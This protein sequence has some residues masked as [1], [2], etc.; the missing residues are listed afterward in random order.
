MAVNKSQ[1][2]LEDN[3]KFQAATQYCYTNFRCKDLN[4]LGATTVWPHPACLL[5][6]GL[7]GES[8]ES[9]GQRSS[10]PAMEAS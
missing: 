8:W 9:Q 6:W 3:S 5:K 4:E 1:V 10:S 7:V 2:H